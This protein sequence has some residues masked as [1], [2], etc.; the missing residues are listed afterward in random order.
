MKR[1]AVNGIL[2]LYHHPL[3]RNAPTIMEHVNAF[4]RYSQF[5]VWGVNTELGF[6]MGLRDLEFRVILFHYSLFAWLPFALDDQFLQY[7]E[8]SQDSYKIAFFQD[9]HRY[10]PQRSEFI[11]RCKVDCV[12]TLVEPAYFEET[13]Q[14][15]TRVPNLVYTLPGYVSD[16]LVKLARRLTKP[17]RDRE[18]DVGYR[19]RRLSFYMGKGSQEKHMIAVGFQE[20][21]ADLGLNLDIQTGEDNR[22]YGRKW[23]EFLASCRAVLGVESGV[24]VFDIDDNVRPQYERLVAERPNLSFEEAHEKLLY[25]YEDNIPYRTI[26]P[27]HFEASALRLC[28]ILFEGKYSGVMQ[29]MVHYIPLMK[30]FSN[31]DEAIR[32]FKE[33]ALRRELTENAYRDLIASGQYSYHNFVQEDFDPVL[34]KAGLRPEIDPEEANWVGACLKQGSYRRHLY[35]ILNNSYGTLGSVAYRHLPRMVSLAKPLFREHGQLK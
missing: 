7:I 19:G 23:Y 20:R 18:I 2:L 21:A 16:N 12:Y 11:N 31:F 14:K 29:P 17:D 28:Q 25:Q 13:Y 22:I 34:L 9:E 6:P 4:E 5:K 27:R 26:S 3:R 30:D 8:E 10:W 32:M 24:S 1:A 35:A 33:P 15:H